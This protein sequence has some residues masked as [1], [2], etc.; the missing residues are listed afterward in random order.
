MRG[1]KKTCVGVCVGRDADRDRGEGEEEKQ[2]TLE[3][4]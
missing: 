4:V 1:I 2:G 3:K